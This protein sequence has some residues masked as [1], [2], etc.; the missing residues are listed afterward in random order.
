[1]TYTYVHYIRHIH[2]YV[3]TYIRMTYTYTHTH[4]HT[5]TV[6]LTAEH[7]VLP[8]KNF[9]DLLSDL[10]T[11]TPKGAPSWLGAEKGRLPKLYSPGPGS[12]CHEKKEYKTSGSTLE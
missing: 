3:R 1:M 4:T 6:V 9:C 2:M 7:T 8:K 10:A 5:H 12:F 11:D